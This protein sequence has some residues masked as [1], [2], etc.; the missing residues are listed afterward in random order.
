VNVKLYESRQE[1]IDMAFAPMTK[2]HVLER[3]TDIMTR[4]GEGYDAQELFHKLNK[5]FAL[6]YADLKQL[7]DETVVDG[8][9][10]VTAGPVPRYK[11]KL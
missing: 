4:S 7:L 6:E 10:T 8:A 9:F 11:L 3:L 1:E 2:K 5:E